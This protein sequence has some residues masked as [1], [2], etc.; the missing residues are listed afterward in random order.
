MSVCVKGLEMVSDPIT[1]NIKVT[2]KVFCKLQDFTIL[3][4]AEILPTNGGFRDCS[5]VIFLPRSR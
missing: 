4:I 3:N 2:I 5:P 1:T